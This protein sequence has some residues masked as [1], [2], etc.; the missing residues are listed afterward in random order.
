ML[1]LIKIKDPSLKWELLAE[2]Q[3]QTDC[4]IVSDIKTKQSVE[5]ELLTRHHLLPGFCVMRAY[6]FYKELF[7]SLNLNWNLTSDAFV[8]ELFSEFCAKHKESGIKNLQNSNSFF[9]FFNVFLVVLFHQENAPLFMEWFNTKHKPVVW[10][11]WFELCQ[12]F[13]HFLESKKMIHESGLKALLLNHLPSIDTL[14]FHKERIFVDLAFSFDLCEKDIFQELSRHKEIY[15]LSP[16]L[17]NQWAGEP[18]FDVYQ[19]RAEGSDEKQSASFDFDLKKALSTKKSLPVRFFKVQ[20]KTQLEELRKA[21]AQVCKWLNSGVHPQDI[22]IFAPYIEDYWFALKAYFERENIPFKKS[23]VAQLAHFPDIRYFLSAM[24]IHLGYFTFEDLEHFSFYRESKRN[25]SKFKWACFNVPHRDFAKQQLFKG[26]SLSSNQKIF[27][28]QF[29][30]WAL[31]FWPKTGEDFLLEKL[32][33]I[34]QNF[35][36]EESLKASAWLKL[37]ESELFSVETELEEEAGRGISCLSFNAFHSLKSPYVFIMG[38]DEESLKPVSLGILNKSERVGIL[39]DL[40]FPLPFSQPK[41]KENSLLWFLKS[42]HHKEVYLSFARYNFMGDIRTASALYLLSESLFD[43]GTKEIS[44]SL[45]WDYNKKQMDISRILSSSPIKKERA[46]ALKKAFQNK[47]SSFFHRDKIQ[48]SPQSLKL[49][50]DCPFK[51][52]AQKLFFVAEKTPVDREISALSKGS[53]AHKLFEGLLRKYPDLHPQ[54]EQV[55][56]LIE[57]IKPKKEELVY[58]KQWLLIKNHLKHLLNLFLEKER[59]D[60]RR[61]PFLK[62]D[63]FEKE[64]FAYW[65][66]KKGELSSTGQYVFQGRVDRIDKDEANN[67]YVIRDYK[68]SDTGLTHLSRWIKENK[69]DLQ[70][71]FYTQSLEKGLIKDLPAHPVSAVFYSVYNKDFLAKGFV[72]KDSSLEDLMGDG[73]GHKKERDVLSQAILAS[74]KKTQTLVQLM[75]GGQFSPRPKIEKICEKCSYRTWCRVETLTGEDQ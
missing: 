25:F 36:M 55:D 35:P 41:E 49:Y 56:Q 68:A 9:E 23:V 62:P 53:I 59:E 22:V 48:L 57:D 17:E 38:L 24:R 46:T 40:G 28:R 20:N 31:S 73:R 33:N 6:E 45:L 51:Y 60:R 37:F 29:I 52:A 30:E 7:Y 72:E 69:E 39:N 1:K 19:K 27:G 74:N 71:T 42:S 47:K 21:L 58:E 67:T 61:F 5:S 11:S 32:L 12:E 34:F 8:K 4:F 75:E 63:A 66:Q 10:K 18:V 2:F 14:S 26:K 44:E 54:S 3:P 16:E 15:I 64:C 50:S 43:A 65:D 70:L 13:F